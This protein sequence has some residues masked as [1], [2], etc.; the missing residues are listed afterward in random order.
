MI[1]LIGMEMPDYPTFEWI[2]FGI[3]IGIIG[4]VIV[5]FY[6]IYKRRIREID[7]S[8]MIVFKR[9]LREDKIKIIIFTLI[10][11]V[12]G[13][14]SFLTF[15]IM[16]RLMGGFDIMVVRVF[17]SYIINFFLLYLGIAYTIAFT[18]T[19]IINAKKNGTLSWFLSKPIRRWEFLWGRILSY[20]F[21]SI[22]ISFACSISIL[23]GGFFSFG[24]FYIEDILSIAGFIFLINILALLTLT[25]IGVFLS[26][27][28]RKTG[29]AIFIPI[30]MFMILPTIV[31]F[32]PIVVRSEWPLLFS[33]SYYF[34]ELSS[35]WISQFGGGLSSIYLA[36]SELL[37]IEIHTLKLSAIHI[38]LILIVLSIALLIISTLYL[39]KTDIS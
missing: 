6:T 2:L 10:S 31:S 35:V 25:A 30:F 1:N 7:S 9:K 19:G 24:F 16:N 17:I 34:E 8:L 14:I 15:T 36:Y 20:L 33:F 26:S 32:L 38:V 39:Q 13:V 3:I 37:G 29:L 21:T 28:F 4:I 22:L 5:I 12:P 27:V 18:S 23:M 11:I